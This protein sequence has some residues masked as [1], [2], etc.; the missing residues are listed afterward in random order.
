ME[1]FLN[2][3][4]KLSATQ[5]KLKTSLLHKHASHYFGRLLQ[6]SYVYSLFFNHAMSLNIRFFNKQS[7]ALS[8]NFF[9]FGTMQ[10][11]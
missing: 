1:I 3:V 5:T 6:A 4:V 10:T 8:H 7:A 9:T 2:K 11:N